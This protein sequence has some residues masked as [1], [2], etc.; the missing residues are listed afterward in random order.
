[1]IKSPLSFCE[2][3]VIHLVTARR[4][5][6]AFQVLIYSDV[7]D[8]LLTVSDN[9]LFYKSGP[10]D[11]VRVAAGIEGFPGKISKQLVGFVEDDDRQF[12]ADILLTQESTFVPRRHLQSIWVEI[13]VP[14]GT[15]A[16]EYEGQV[17][18][19]RHRLFDAE[20]KLGELNFT[21]EVKDVTLPLPEEYHFYLDLW[22]HSAN[23]SRKHEVPLW[24]D[25]HFAVLEK[26]VASLAALGQK[27]VTVIA[28]EIPWS[29]QGSA[30]DLV[31]PSDLFEYNMVRVRRDG[32]GRFI[33]DYSILDRYVELCSRYGIRD[34]IEVFGLVNIWLS[35]EGGLTG[36]V[37]YID[38]IRIRYYD[39]ARG[40]YAFM[41]KG[42]EIEDYIGALEE[43]FASRGWLEKVRV[44]AD[45][46]ADTELYMRRLENLRR[47]APRFKFKAAINHEEMFLNPP[48]N[49]LDFV[50]SFGFLRGYWPN[51]TSLR[52][53]VP[54]RLLWYV[55]CGPEWPN[56]F[57][58][59]PLIENRLIPILTF[60][61]G[62]DG[63]LRWNY[64]VWPE[65]PR[66]RISFRAPYWPAGDTNFVYPGNFGG[67]L[68]TLRYKNLLKGIQ[69]FEL[70][71]MLRARAGEAS[72]EVI[73]AY[74]KEVLN[75]GEG[76]WKRERFYSLDEADYE[77]GKKMLLE[78]LEDGPGG[79]K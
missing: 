60:F 74:F 8:F 31:Y 23:I 49:L 48:S 36:A 73:Q 54:G 42:E 39:E 4:G 75:Q 34:E 40:V 52:Q 18:I 1:M 25:E 70:L 33:Y 32:E 30:L 41:R 46:P 14:E 50:P 2:E 28:S 38:D 53:K 29:G 43:H 67:P 62:F 9:T 51:F 35:P 26:Y 57:I 63:F 76:E 66:H 20:E 7:E 24:S 45:E 64:T 59:S 72:K 22:Q 68:L 56:T 78:A 55:C 17:T 11:I 10:I 27:A 15:P 12:K 69:D 5:L 77:R 21:V 16:G 19:W 58:R 71:Y 65:D 3:R 13:E 37:D 61:M 6:C 47:V 44:V 79:G